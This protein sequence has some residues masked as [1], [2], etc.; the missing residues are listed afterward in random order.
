MNTTELLV[1]AI[2]AVILLVS[3]EVSNKNERGYN[4]IDEIRWGQQ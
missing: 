2:A 1:C 3:F 4:A